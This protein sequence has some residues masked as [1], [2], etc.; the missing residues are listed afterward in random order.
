MKKLLLFL[1]PILIFIS[2]G[3]ELETV[4]VRP[5]QSDLFA[6]PD[7]IEGLA[8]TAET[9]DFI[10]I[11]IGEI[12]TIESLDPL[13]ATSNSEWRII[14]LL[15]DRLVQ[16]DDNEN[17]IPALAKRWQVN[18]DSTRFT[19][20]LKSNERFHSSPVFDSGN[21]RRVKADDVRFVF[22]RMS[23]D[24][25][26][27]SVA[28]KFDDIRG[29]AA[30]QSE[31]KLVK[32]PE[33]WAYDRIDGIRVQNDTTIIFH[34]INSAPDFLQRLSHPMASIYA[35]ESVKEASGPIQQSAGSGDYRFIRKENGKHMLTMVQ[36]N[37]KNT[38][39]INRLD[40]I[41][42][43]SEKEL[44]Q[45]FAQENLDAL[46]ELGPSTFITVTDS[47]GNFLDAYYQNYDLKD[48]GTI[49]GYS[50]YY[51]QGANNSK[52]LLELFSGL[53][54]EDLADNPPMG[55]FYI[56]N[57]PEIVN[58]DGENEKTEQLIITHSSHP[59]S[60]FLINKLATKATDH[61]ISFSMNA[62]YAVW[63]EIIL[64]HYP[65]TFT[66]EI[67]RWDAPV[68]ILSHKNKAS[69]SIENQPWNL[70]VS[71]VQKAGQN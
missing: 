24:K 61:N 16:L 25:V 23:S 15:Y 45:Q 2:C 30:Y 36:N 55:T 48:T 4:T 66:K 43:F 68:Y 34:T 19:F 38:P 22:E 56:K 53:T 37:Q 11:K 50:V 1:I 31:R 32:N 12:A 64:S 28:A 58:T 9:D 14:H 42:G 62:S 69:F 5:D 35:P 3:S 70:K 54:E 51:N 41:S 29:F 39:R 44:Y 40:I 13:F 57:D 8:D 67:L 33:K 65:Y 71:A 47:A 46:I 6:A 63:D 7:S 17:P 60:V 52:P 26:P 20:H 59:F 27:P 21:G 49:S 18:E 10:H